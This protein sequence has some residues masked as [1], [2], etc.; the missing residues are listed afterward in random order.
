MESMTTSV[1]R[2]RSTQNELLSMLAFRN[3]LAAEMVGQ[4]GV[5]GTFSPA[6]GEYFPPEL[7]NARAPGFANSQ[8]GVSDAAAIPTTA[9]IMSNNAILARDTVIL[10]PWRRLISPCYPE[11]SGLF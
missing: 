5:Q 7:K 4:T 2:F 9:V 6:H 8:L 11:P 10:T 1:P 3:S